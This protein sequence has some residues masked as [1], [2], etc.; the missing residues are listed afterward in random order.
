MFKT[1]DTLFNGIQKSDY[2]FLGQMPVIHDYY[3]EAGTCEADIERMTM[4]YEMLILRCGV[5]KEI[6]ENCFKTNRLDALIRVYLCD[7][8]LTI[9]NTYIES[10]ENPIEKLP[11]PNPDA[12]PNCNTP[13][14]ITQQ[15]QTSPPDC[16]RCFS[17][18]CTRCSARGDGTYVCNNCRGIKKDE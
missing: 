3:G 4:I 17:I 16:G 11:L 15:R 10:R 9:G 8:T 14:F 6:I 18:I 1:V 12:C 7:E 2:D 5:K 13:G